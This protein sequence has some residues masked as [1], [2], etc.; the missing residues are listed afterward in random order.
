MKRCPQCHRVETDDSL[1][2]CRTDG[3]ALLTNSSSA[4]SEAG[5]AKLGSASA[6]KEIETSTTPQSGEVAVGRG[7]GPT[8]VLAA[9]P[10]LSTTRKLTRGSKQKFLIAV[11]ALLIVVGLAGYSYLS[12][13]NTSAIQSIAVMP[14]VNVSGNADIEYLSDGMTE[15]LISS[16]SQLAHLNV[17][18]RSTVFYYKGK[19]I[20]AKKLGEDLSVQAVLLGRVVQNGDDLKLSLELVNTGTQDVIWSEQYD[21]KK[22]DLITLQTDIARDVSNKLKTK[23]SGEDVAKLSGVHTANPE[24]YERYLKGKYYSNQFTKQGLQ[25]GVDSFNQAIAIDPNYSRAY[26]GLAY[27]YILLDDWFMPP[28][29]SVAK[30]RENAT[31]AIA[32]DETDA[33]AHLVLGMVAHWYDWDWKKA[34]DEFKRTIVLN[35]KSCEAFTYYAYFLSSMKR[36]TEALNIARAGLQI[37]PLSS[38]ANFSVASALLFSRHWDEATTH[39]QNAIKIDPNYWF[40]RL[41]LGR[42]YEQKRMMPE[43][44]AEFRRAVDLDSEQSENWSGLAHALAVSGKKAEA[45]KIVNDLI[46]K[47]RAGSYVSPYN[48][49]VV[50]VG[51]G[52]RESALN[53]LERAYEERS[54][55]LPVYLTT[56]ERL[57]PLHDDPRFRV[58]VRR[59]GLPE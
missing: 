10:Q 34:E 52:D 43:A 57:E 22:S 59:I 20:T 14:F 54:Y 40:H 33:D 5:T 11:A 50:Y 24:A 58:L 27:T 35:P 3:A 38:L 8:T 56:D 12:R 25:L 49:A 53:W 16:L 15:T 13:R 1:V 2:F 9:Q 37:D 26:S 7:S 39:L 30:A 51:L 21:R 17:K 23:L 44:I 31:K 18:A 28:H 48:I 29:E 42:C 36:D 46:T 19:E 6:S 55:Y 32:I 47:S 45:E 4:G 41:Y